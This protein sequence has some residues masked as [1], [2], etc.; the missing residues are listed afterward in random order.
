M[1]GPRAEPP[2]W[3][4][5]DLGITI[6]LAVLAVLW[7]LSYWRHNVSLTDEAHLVHL[8]GRLLA[9]E[10]PYRDFHTIYAPGRH[11]LAAFL[12]LFTGPSLLTVHAQHL[13]LRALSV[14]LAYALGRQVMRPLG[15]LVPAV[16]LLLV[17]GAWHKVYYT[18]FSLLGLLVL[19]WFYRRPRMA[20]AVMLGVT[21]S[22]ACQFRQDVGVMLGILAFILIVV[23]GPRG[24]RLRHLGAY[25][26]S[27]LLTAAPLL[28]Y[29][30]L[31]GALTDTIWLLSLPVRT[32][33]PHWEIP[34]S[35]ITLGADRGAMA[36]R[37]MVSA[38][39][40][41][42]L[43]TLIFVLLRSL[44][45]LIRSRRLATRDALL[46]LIALIGI[47]GANQMFRYDPAAR[48]L[49]CGSPAYLLLAAVFTE[50]VLGLGRVGR[51]AW[52]VPWG[53]AGLL[54][55]QIWT[56][57]P[58]MK[59]GLEYTGAAA[60]RWVEERQPLEVRGETVYIPPT[61]GSTYQST[62]DII[63]KYTGERETLFILGTD[64]LFYHWTGLRNP[65]RFA[66][67]T[68][69][70]WNHVRERHWEETLERLRG[71]RPPV[72]LAR[73]VIAELSFGFQ[74]RWGKKILADYH[75][76]RSIGRWAVFLENDPAA[77]TGR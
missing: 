36:G 27:G 57:G 70:N 68:R 39:M 41:V 63:V 48:L 6:G 47:I 25:L 75:L 29:L 1:T 3:S 33:S 20:T 72:I 44:W 21:I 17:P 14:G 22:L 64:P 73:H 9:G 11:L 51:F 65:T 69:A 5:R 46:F 50:S 10:V 8:A 42:L 2:R 34:R 38:L 62:R 49:Q 4:R 40:L 61:V 67:V 37:G 35:M 31:T 32:D 71:D 18:L 52:L 56:A 53:F 77:G 60:V 76:V 7:F 12:F 43:L 54:G 55:W 13:V 23:H 26:G 45:L 66:W 19:A 28:L 59:L 30:T 16:L 24:D 74:E 15:A 58:D